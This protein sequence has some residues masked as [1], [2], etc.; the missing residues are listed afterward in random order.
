M[1]LKL[2]CCEVLFREMCACIARSPHIIDVEFLTKG[3]HDLG[4]VTMRNRIQ[5]Q[6]DKV[7]PAQYDAILLG[8]A[9][10]G[11]GT[12]EIT[13][14]QIP[15]ILFRAHDCIGVFMGGS[16]L[17]L[18]YVSDH[19]GVYFRSPGWLERGQNLDQLALEQTRRQAGVGY[20]REELIEKY[21]KDNG[22]YLWEQF[23][24]YTKVYRQLTYIRT[25]VEP[26]NR[27][28]QQASQEAASRGWTFDA[29][30]GS[31]HIF[32]RLVNGAWDG[33]EFLVVPRGKTVKPRYD[34]AIMEAV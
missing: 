15:I 21:G 18:R 22:T 7:D 8:Y 31:L 20:T 29:V 14:R 16:D 25:G 4:C 12:A 23:T 27:F 26:D 6:I 17:Y 13:A 9:L 28:E 2:I 33:P 32:E 34:G 24:N 30:N 10:C 11:N 19:P 5:E 1:R 3:L